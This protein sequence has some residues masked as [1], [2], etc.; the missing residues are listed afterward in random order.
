VQIS[1]KEN[2]AQGAMADWRLRAIGPIAQL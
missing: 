2:S 1:Q